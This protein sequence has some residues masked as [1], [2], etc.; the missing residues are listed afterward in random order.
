MPATTGEN[1]TF[2]TYNANARF[3]D[4]AQIDAAKRK[5]CRVNL[6]TVNDKEEMARFIDWGVAGLITDFP[7]TL[8]TL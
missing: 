2:S 5:G 3:I 7:Q 4:K 6:F 1:Y 8:A